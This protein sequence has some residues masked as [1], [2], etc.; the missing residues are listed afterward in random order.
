[1]PKFNPGDK[2][3]IIESTIFI[4][5]VVVVKFSGGMYLVKYP[6][7]NGGYKVRESR[8]YK[9]ESEAKKVIDSKNKNNIGGSIL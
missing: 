2:A 1:M 5:E 3:Y 8:L 9:T 4:K 6:N 7:S